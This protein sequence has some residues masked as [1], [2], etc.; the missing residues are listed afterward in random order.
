MTA[1]GIDPGRWEVVEGTDTNGDDAADGAT[2]T[3]TVDLERSGDLELTFAPRA[4]TIVN[5]RLVSKGTPY[6]ERPD[7]GIGK[8]DVVVQG[9]RVKVTVHSLGSVNAPATTVALLDGSG[10]VLVSAPVPALP[11]P[12]DLMPKTAVVT[13]T[14]PGSVKI[15]GGSVVIDPGNALKEI[16]RINN[17]VGL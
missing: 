14:V 10:K 2:T 15:A 12:L 5:L 9:N 17:R 8:D 13:L 6:W 1:W 7:L 11:A 16:T 3:R 4:A